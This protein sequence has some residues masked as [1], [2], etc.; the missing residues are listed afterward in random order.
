M[1]LTDDEFDAL[2]LATEDYEGLWTAGAILRNRTPNSSGEDLKQ[3]GHGA[4]TSLLEKGL[5]ALYHCSARDNG[6]YKIVLSD[7][8]K[9]VLEKPENW[10]VAV[11]DDV[12]YFCYAS[13]DEGWKAY[14]ENGRERKS[15]R[16]RAEG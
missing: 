12:P 9:D 5:V 6:T 8:V 11:E 13:T 4:I 7:K 15:M 14:E 2:S 1:K 16:K 10:Q 3:R